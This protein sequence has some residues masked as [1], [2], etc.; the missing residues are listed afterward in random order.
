MRKTMMPIM[1]MAAMTMMT[2]TTACSSDDPLS[3]DSTIYGD[4]DDD[5]SSSSSSG[6]SSTG[7]YSEM[8]TF[9]IA[10]DKTTAEPTSTATAQYPEEGDAFSNHTFGTIVN[11]DM[12]S[13]ADPGVEGVTVTID[14]HQVTTDHG[15]TEGICYVVTG[16]TTDGSLVIN[17]SADFELN[18]NNAD[19][20]STTTT[21]IDMEGK[22]SAYMV[23]TGTNKLSDG[24]TED[25]KGTIFS[26]GKLFINGDG[27]LEVYGNY[28]NGIHGKSNIVIEKGVN[29]YV[30][31]TENNGIKAGDNMFINGGIINVEV[32]ADG[33]KAINGDASITINGGRTT[34]IATGNGTW[35]VDETLT[36]GGDT[37]AAA[38]IGCDDTFYMNGGELYAKATGSGGKGVKADLEA[39]I[40]GGKIRIITE[41]GLYYSD[42]S[43]ES[44]NYTGNTDNLPSAYT[45]SPKG[46]KIGYKDDTVTP[47]ET[48]G[49][50]KISG[51]DIMIRT[52]GNNAEGIESKGTLEVSDGTVLVYAHDDAINST[53]DLT[54]SG[55]TVVAVGTNNDGID[56]NGDMYL[57]GGTLIACGA[58]G[59]EAGIDIN[60]QK[61]LYISGGYIFGIGGRFDG[62]LGST[63]QGIIST[64]GSI[65]ANSTVSVSNSSKTLYTFSMPPVSYNNG[66]ILISTPDLSSGSSYTLTSGN[67]SAN[68]TASNTISSGMGGGMQGGGNPGGP[69]GW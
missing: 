41:G 31:S 21:A 57:K 4:N 56:A 23:L 47:T 52:S 40:T 65:S 60:E 20:T 66:T 58:S 27:S 12:S 62:N 1:L 7:T 18:L 29:L 35:E 63:T 11:I 16:T 22:G 25:H 32:S 54:I 64:T 36:Y 44:D 50:L 42:G 46:M 28:K 61:K 10:I 9:T 69:G 45:S 24:T 5:S 2:M 39:Y 67:S 26:K 53:G 68:V 37:K 15:N 59:A 14:G 13:P 8:K 17:G 30:N 51:G 55:G 38:G 48:Y 6:G 19:I 3:N 49:V 43:T 34:V 33:G